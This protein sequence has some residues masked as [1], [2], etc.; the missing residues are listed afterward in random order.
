MQLPRRLF[1]DDSVSG[2][3]ASIASLINS[4]LSN[5]AHRLLS[6][7]CRGGATA[8]LIARFDGSVF[9]PLVGPVNGAGPSINGLSGGWVTS[10]TVYLD[11]LYIAGTF[12]QLG[13]QRTWARYVVAWNGSAWWPLPNTGLSYYV[14]AFAI[15][16]NQL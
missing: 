2:I 3:Y 7:P 5:R 13:D 14:H 11:R 1:L 15:F 8:N 12:Y 16:Q 4:L 9:S 10:M 6:L